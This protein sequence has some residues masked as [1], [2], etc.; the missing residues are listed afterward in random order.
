M[1]KVK[2]IGG[3]DNGDGDGDVRGEGGFQ[4]NVVVTV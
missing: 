1:S 4:M 2:E 3:G